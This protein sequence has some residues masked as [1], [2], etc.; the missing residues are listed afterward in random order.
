MAASIKRHTLSRFAT[1]GP[2]AK[3]ENRMRQG[4]GRAIPTPANTMDAGSLS[5][6]EPGSAQGGKKVS[7]F[8]VFFEPITSFFA[9]V[10]SEYGLKK[11]FNK[12]QTI[13]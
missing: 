12:T 10:F 13:N 8:F 6:W 1:N 11:V 7:G 3:V 9:Q 4:L 5:A 2:R